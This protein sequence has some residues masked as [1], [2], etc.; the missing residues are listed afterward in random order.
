MISLIGT[1]L[2]ES[3]VVHSERRGRQIE[4]PIRRG[5]M[6][7]A[8]ALERQKDKL[9]SFSLFVN[10]D[11]EFVRSPERDIKARVERPTRLALLHPDY[12]ILSANLIM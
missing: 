11:S 9:A 5:S 8:H 3:Q 10:D 2:L 12:G 4:P 1:A 6:R 7:Q